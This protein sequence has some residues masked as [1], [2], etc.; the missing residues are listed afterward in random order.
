M[1]L[2]R[3][4]SAMLDSRAN[5]VTMNGITRGIRGTVVAAGVLIGAAAQAGLVTTDLTSGQTANSLVTAMLGEGVSV[6]NVVYRGCPA[7]G[8]QF[9]GGTGIVG[10]ES[11]IML[12]SGSVA[13]AVGPNTDGATSTICDA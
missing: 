5:E 3:R 12:G 10:F 2:L 7:G 11:G 6:S 8:G 4:L 9:S 1:A 13:A